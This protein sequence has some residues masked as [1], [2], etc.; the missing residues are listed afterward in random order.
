M[1]AVIDD[2]AT[3]FKVAEGDTIEIDVRD[4]EVGSQVNFDKVALI[5]G[6]DGTKV[7]T[8]YVEGAVVTGIVLG[9]NKGPKV[10]T[11]HFRRRKDS[12]TREGHRQK[13]LQVKID[14]IQG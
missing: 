10:I 6:E 5:E 11:N 2:S 12:K 13:Y 1:I 3:Q 4:A 14:K 9:E 8:P 7:G